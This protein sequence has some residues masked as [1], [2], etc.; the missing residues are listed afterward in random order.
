MTSIVIE[1]LQRR[2]GRCA[3][4]LALEARML[5]RRGTL[6]AVDGSRRRCEH[7]TGGRVDARFLLNRASLVQARTGSGTAACRLTPTCSMSHTAL[8]LAPS[9]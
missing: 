7:R 2:S 3:S 8:I 5:L 6:A 1:R 9:Y 4:G